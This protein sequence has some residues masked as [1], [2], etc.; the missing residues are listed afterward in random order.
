MQEYVTLSIN[1]AQVRAV[2]GITV[3]DAA[4]EYGVCIPHLCHMQ[5]FSALGACRLC[6]VEV[7][8]NGRRKVTTS[9]TLGVEE[10]LAIV[11]HSEKIVR[12][13]RNIAELLVAET[14]NSKAIQDLAIRCGVKEVRYPFHNVDCVQCGRCV[15]V[16][17]QMWQAKA[18]GF[19]GRGKDRHVDFPLAKRPDFCKRCNSC[20]DL[21]PMTIPPCP[22][23]WKPGEERLCGLCESQLSMV[24][25]MPESCVECELGTSF[26][27]TRAP[28]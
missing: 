25:T 26:G 22:G 2:K 4:L 27:C 8:K 23:P 28:A 19:V 9:C 13:R 10:G 3:L 16:C 7:V 17:E 21:C 18:L 6:I 24:E 15:R 5:G 14:P 1:G 20:I 11:T 12:L